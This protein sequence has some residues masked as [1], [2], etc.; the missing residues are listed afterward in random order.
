MINMKTKW[1]RAQNFSKTI[2]IKFILNKTKD[3]F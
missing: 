1:S 2:K 3:K